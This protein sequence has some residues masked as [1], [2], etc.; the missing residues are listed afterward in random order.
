MKIGIVGA[1]EE[2][3]SRFR[4]LLDGETVEERAGSAYYS[5]RIRNL[6]AVV[7]QCG[8][9]KV[10]AAVSTQVM[11]DAYAVDALIITGVAGALDPSLEIGDLVVSEECR[12]HDM[13]ATALGFERGEIPFAEHSVFPADPEL[14][15]IAVQ[16]GKRVAEG[17]VKS[18]LIL[19]GDQFIAHRETVRDMYE[20][21]GALCTEMEGAAV[22]HVCHRNEIPFVII[23]SVSD[24][25]DGS[26][27][28]DFAEFSRAAA[29]KSCDL[30]LT[31]MERLG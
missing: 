26:A 11:I 4:R 27:H 2:E 1:M 5:G 3:I 12:Y 18:G 31:L 16:E 22:A 20:R 24:R 23:R 21:W 6:N 7:C 25:A 17:K 13:D 15:K 14:V 19:S 9:G 30:V 8:V 29:G 28:V 10:N